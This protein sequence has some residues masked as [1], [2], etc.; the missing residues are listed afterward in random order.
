[1]IFSSNPIILYD[2]Y[3]KREEVRD[4]AIKATVFPPWS[5][6]KAPKSVGA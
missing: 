6:H 1:M 4:V 3:G 2:E 5:A